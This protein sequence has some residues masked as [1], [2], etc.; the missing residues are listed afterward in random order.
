MSE[1]NVA[2]VRGLIDAWSSGDLE[3]FLGTLDENVEWRFADNFVYGKVNP[4]IGRDA[5]R[6]GS[7]ARLRTDWEGFDAVISEL[8][9]AGDQVVVLGHYVGTFKATRRTLRA[10]FTHVYTL[11]DERI[12]R[13]RQCVDTKAFDEAMAPTPATK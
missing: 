12:V 4:L 8:L 5:L 10:Q 7:L 9:D 3:R 13:W 6:T 11:K 2:I 1:R